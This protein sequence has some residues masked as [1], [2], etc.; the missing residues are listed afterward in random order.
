[1]FH[2][3]GDERDL[4]S[5]RCYRIASRTVIRKLVF[6]LCA[7]AMLGA[8]SGGWVVM[9]EKYRDARL[10]AMMAHMTEVM[11][12][13]RRDPNIDRPAG[14]TVQAKLMA[15][16]ASPK[17]MVVGNLRTLFIEGSST[18]GE[19]L[20]FSVT[21][22]N[23]S[24]ALGEKSELKDAESGFYTPVPSKTV[25]GFPMYGEPGCIVVTRRPGSPTIPVSRERAARALIAM[26]E[27][28]PT[29]V[30]KIRRELAAMSS[31]QRSAPAIVDLSPIVALQLGDRADAPVF[32]ATDGEGRIRL[33]AP[34]PAFYDRGRLDD[35][36]VLAISFDCL[37]G[38]G[39]P[40]CAGF[41]GVFERVRDNIDWSALA[42]L[43]KP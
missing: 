16:Q 34:N 32:A 17:K 40:F 20:G 12:V 5:R 9:P 41:K 39:S 4:Q 8:Q 38:H 35:V 30:A 33:F 36:Q 15:S 31:A 23:T 18:R 22:N 13:L 10:T 28:E 42:Q 2:D 43:V 14:Y 6:A 24:C 19:G 25:H 21:A 37:D 7:P 1:M 3:Y 27:S 26:H 11:A 29:V